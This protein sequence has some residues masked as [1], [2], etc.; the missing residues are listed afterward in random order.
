MLDGADA[1]HL[2]GG[3]PQPS[4]C[5][6]R[7]LPRQADTGPSSG[8]TPGCRKKS[9][10]SAA[11]P[12]CASSRRVRSA[13]R[14]SSSARRSGPSARKARRCRNRRHG[15]HSTPRSG[16]RDRRES[17]R[18]PTDARNTAWGRGIVMR[19]HRDHA[20][21]DHSPGCPQAIHDRQSGR[22][23]F[24]RRAAGG[25]LRHT[26]LEAGAGRCARCA[27]P[28][29]ITRRAPILFGAMCPPTGGVDRGATLDAGPVRIRTG[30]RCG[31][32]SDPRVVA[33]KIARLPS[34][35]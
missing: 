17:L 26:G 30:M 29:L 18:H 15:V 2:E 31:D 35:T 25:D 33:R 27:C 11:V 34:L 16:R 8:S 3:R 24:P 5:P 10:Q 4:R 22:R 9:A 7:R 20:A 1:V 13:P 14:R 21:H 23:R 32:R 6:L 12:R 28:L 19:A